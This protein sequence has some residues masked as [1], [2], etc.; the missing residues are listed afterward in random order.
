MLHLAVLRE[1]GSITKLLLRHGADVDAANKKG[2]TALHLAVYRRDDDSAEILL[3]CEAE[4]NAQNEDGETPLHLAA[5]RGY[6]TLVQLFLDK[7]ADA[8]MCAELGVSE[9][10]I[11][12]KN[13]K[14][15]TPLQVAI[16]GRHFVVLKKLAVVG[17]ANIDAQNEKGETALHVATWNND[18]E[19]VQV[20]LD[21]RA[22]ID[23]KDDRGQTALYLAT[24]REHEDLVILLL[25]KGADPNAANKRYNE[26]PLY[27]AVSLRNLSLVQILLEG[28]ANPNISRKDDW[29]ALME[30][31]QEDYA[32]IVEALVEA[33]VD[34]Y[35]EDDRGRTAREIAEKRGFTEIAEILRDYEATV[36]RR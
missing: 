21:S 30:A 12:M 20:L 17:K 1:Y 16:S 34:A 18:G 36:E 29:T 9:L 7:R 4:V 31:A 8:N 13:G 5:Y 33:G 24:A 3:D 28:N 25:K 26:T 11:D 32:D 15:H 6:E 27:K 10:Q 19:L 2:E 22:S 35:A 14:D 23:M